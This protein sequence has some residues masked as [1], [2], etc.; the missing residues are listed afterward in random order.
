MLPEGLRDET[1]VIFASA[2]PGVDRFADELRSATTRYES[3][4]AQKRQ[5]QDLLR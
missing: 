2:F 3:R 1:G 4:L 5:L